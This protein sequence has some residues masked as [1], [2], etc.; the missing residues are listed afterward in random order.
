ML[1][2]LRK[3]LYKVTPHRLEFLNQNPWLARYDVGEFSYGN[4]KVVNWAEGSTL[5][6]GRF[7]SVS[8][9][10][11]ILLGGEHRIDWVT[12]FPFPEVLGNVEQFPGYV[13]TK[14]D[15][16][17]G[18]DVWIGDS[19][20]VLSGVRVGN[21]AVIGAGSVVAKSV[22]AYAVVTGNPAEFLFY[23]F[24]A[25]QIAALERIAWWD[26]PIEKVKENLPLLLSG[27][28][29]AFIAKHDHEAPET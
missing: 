29:G 8:P 17:I 23:R 16:I 19:A 5:R 7:C 24:P 27:D 12:T 9:T 28:V 14:G 25:E 10:T 22:P 1:L 3:L 21:G 15:V 11:T 20:I 18:N 13:R 6:I 2:K 4:V 26:W